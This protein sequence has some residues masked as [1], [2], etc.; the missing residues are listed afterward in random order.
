[1]THNI[2]SYLSGSLR[3]CLLALLAVAMCPSEM[4]AQSKLYVSGSAVPGGTQELTVFTVDGK[5]QF[6]FH[7]KLL[8]GKLCIQ[9]TAA[10]RA[11]TVYYAPRQVD[12]N[13][14]NDGISITQKRDSVAGEW[15]VL[16]EAD[17]YRFTYD[18][19]TQKVTGEVFPLWYE[20]WITGGCVEDNQGSGSSAGNWQL[21]AGKAMEQSDDDPYV[22]TWTGELKVYSSNDESNKLK[23][24]G[25]YGWSPK[26]LHPVATDQ[27]LTSAKQVWYNG[28]KDTKWTISKDGYYTVTINVFLETI[29]AE[30]LG[31]ELPS[32]M[33]ATPELEADIRTAGRDITVTA[34]TAVDC[35]LYTLGGELIATANGSQVK[36]AA[37][38]AG[39]YLI[40]VHDGHRGISRKI[41]TD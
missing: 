22:W 12:S 3:G 37:P 39:T 30:Y 35:R 36:M 25:Q 4:S 21:S 29:S 16:F 18:V 38:A 24:N 19:S 8:P 7:G 20:A 27:A 14:V 17:N 33:Q 11:S 5:R 13:I 41:V 15:T 26:V 6:K 9:T 10:R 23:I 32:G 1:M 34:A 31:T 28:S 40:Y 2:S